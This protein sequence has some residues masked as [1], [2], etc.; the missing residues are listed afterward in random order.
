M[1]GHPCHHVQYLYYEFIIYNIIFVS[2]HRR[3]RRGRR[4]VC[5]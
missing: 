5:V 3:S 2:L 4:R 1:E